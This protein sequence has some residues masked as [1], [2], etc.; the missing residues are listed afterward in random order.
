MAQATKQTP[1][2]WGTAIVGFGVRK[3]ALAGGRTGEICSIGFSSRKADISVYGVAGE[4]A[5]KDILQKLGKYK[6][7]KGCLYISRLADVHVSLL[8]TLCAEASHRNTRA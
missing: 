7:G 2:M 3:Y 8:K 1:K 5:N 4:N 6:Q